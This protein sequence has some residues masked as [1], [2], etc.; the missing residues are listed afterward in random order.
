MDKP[1]ISEPQSGFLT[2]EILE[3]IDAYYLRE[4]TR[5]ERDRDTQR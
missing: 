5:G 4:G 3:F 2:V 1:Q